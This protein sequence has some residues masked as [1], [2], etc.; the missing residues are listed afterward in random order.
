MLHTIYDP[1]LTLSR[2]I[3][4]GVLGVTNRTATYTRI[5]RAVINR[6]ESFFTAQTVQVVREWLDGLPLDPEERAHAQRSFDPGMPWAWVEV[7]HRYEHAARE[8]LASL[9]VER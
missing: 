7:P 9:P 4:T 5:G 6:P 2:P 3:Q 1:T 8:L